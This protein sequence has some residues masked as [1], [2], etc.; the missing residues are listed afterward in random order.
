MQKDGLLDSEDGA[1]HYKYPGMKKLLGFV[2]DEINKLNRN[3]IHVIQEIDSNLEKADVLS[4]VL[5]QRITYLN[6]KDKESIEE[7]FDEFSKNFVAIREKLN[8]LCIQWYKK[9]LEYTEKENYEG[10]EK[11]TQKFQIEEIIIQSAQKLR[12]NMLHLFKQLAV[13]G[14]MINVKF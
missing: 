9:L 5:K 7:I 14:Y 1:W 6:E 13:K 4:Y 12:K 3:G 11:V 8:V 2:Q 10:Y